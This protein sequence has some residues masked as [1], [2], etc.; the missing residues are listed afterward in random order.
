M[1]ARRTVLGL[2]TVGALALAGCDSDVLGRQYPPYRY[3][4][5]AVVETPAGLRS[6]SSVI[7][8]RW[9]EAGTAFG[10][11]GSAGFSVKGE[12]VAV[13]LAKDEVLFVLLRS[14]G[15]SDWAAWALRDVVP[16]LKDPRGTDRKPHPVPR[17]IEI[18]REQVDNYPMFV[19]FRDPADP[20]SVEQVDPDDLAKTF[21]PGYRLKSLTV[22]VTDEPVTSGIEKR[23]G[24]LGNLQARNARLNGSSSAAISTNDLSDNLGAGNFSTEVGK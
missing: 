14:S 15:S 18:Q 10:I 23:L 20:K 24:W 21:G 1:I 4:L 12:A 17:R 13:E 3:R 5:T 16:N 19:R 8:V 6:G 9:T 11:L 2:V 7:Q 22:Q